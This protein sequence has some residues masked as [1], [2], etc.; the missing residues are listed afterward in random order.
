[1]ELAKSAPAI[2]SAAKE[3]AATAEDVQL[4]SASVTSAFKVDSS[5]TTFQT[6]VTFVRAGAWSDR[7]GVAIRTRAAIFPYPHGPKTHHLVKKE[8]R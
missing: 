2:R 7:L 4:A 1:M 8:R 6:T 3:S 5:A